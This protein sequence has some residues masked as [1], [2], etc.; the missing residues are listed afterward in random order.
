[1]ADTVTV[2]VQRKLFWHNKRIRW[3]SDDPFEVPKEIAEDNPYTLAP[4]DSESS[5]TV[6]A[7]IAPSDYT[8][9][10]LETELGDE[11]YSDEELTAIRNKEKKN[12]NRQGALDALD[13][14]LEA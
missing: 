4:V 5:D 1:M 3:P 13:A 2:R 9:G 7:P 11:D 10:E 14:E 8:V 6:E 12:K